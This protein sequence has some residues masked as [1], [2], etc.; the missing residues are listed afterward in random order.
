MV[1]GCFGSPWVESG[2]WILAP[3]E[4]EE[5]PGDGTERV[6]MCM[7]KSPRQVCDKLFRARSPIMGGSVIM[8]FGETRDTKR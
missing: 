8:S 3:N 1:R 6:A 7:G 5:S 2:L 4:V